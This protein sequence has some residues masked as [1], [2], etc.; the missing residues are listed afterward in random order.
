MSRA[1]ARFFN[2]APVLILE[3][4]GG[5]GKSTGGEYTQERIFKKTKIRPILLRTDDIPYPGGDPANRFVSD[6]EKEERYQ[7]VARRM[8][9][10]KHTDPHRPIIVEGAFNLQKFRNIVL[11][12]AQENNLNAYQALLTGP[13]STRLKR[14]RLHESNT[15]KRGAKAKRYGSGLTSRN[16]IKYRPALEEFEPISQTHSVIDNGPDIRRSDLGRQFDSFLNPILDRHSTTRLRDTQVRSFFRTLDAKPLDARE[17]VKHMLLFLRKEFGYQEK[18]RASFL[19]LQPSENGRYDHTNLQ[20]WH[21]YDEDKGQGEHI[22]HELRKGPIKAFSVT[23]ATWRDGQNYFQ[24]RYMPHERDRQYDSRI[25]KLTRTRQDNGMYFPIHAPSRERAQADHP[26]GQL[27]LQ[28][29]G[30]VALYS[31]KSKNPETYHQVGR[32]LRLGERYVQKWLTEDWKTHD[33]A[34][35]HV[36]SLIQHVDQNEQN[37]PDRRGYSLRIASLARQLGQ[38]TGQFTPQQLDQLEAAAHLHDAGKYFGQD[39]ERPMSPDQLLPH[40]QPNHPLAKAVYDYQQLTTAPAAMLQ[41]TQNNRWRAYSLGIIGELTEKEKN[42]VWTGRTKLEDVWR[43]HIQTIYN[44]P[45]QMDKLREG[46]LDI[47]TMTE[48][49]F[50]G[51]ANGLIDLRHTPLSVRQKQGL[52]D[53]FVVH[54]FTYLIQEAKH[55]E[56]QGTLE[57]TADK[58]NEI[59]RNIRQMGNIQSEVPNL[60]VY[61]LDPEELE[62][63]QQTKEK[64]VHII[65]NRAT[66]PIAALDTFKNHH[67]AWNKPEF[68]R[69][70]PLLQ[71][72]RLLGHNLKSIGNVPAILDGP[73]VRVLRQRIPAIV[74]QIQ[75]KIGQLKEEHRTVIQA[76]GITGKELE[77][78]ELLESTLSSEHVSQLLHRMDYLKPHENR[79]VFDVRELVKQF[80]N[81]KTTTLDIQ[82]RQPIMVLGKPSVLLDAIDNLL[83]NA[84]QHPRPGVPPTPKLSLQTVQEDGKN[85]VEL[86]VSDQGKG[87]PND[88]L[89][90]VAITHKGAATAETAPL[91]F[92]KGFT[93]RG[94]QGT[95]RGLDYVWQ[96]VKSHGGTIAVQSQ[97]GQGT[98]FR[99]RLPLAAPTNT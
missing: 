7:E 16:M 80:V 84:T 53:S 28:P 9:D 95:G 96:T 23:A 74:R 48:H 81:P 15:R 24:Q 61:D 88:L 77:N 40:F 21:A 29:M 50:H 10:S 98:T 92:H 57:P 30:I 31:E 85:W 94:E 75:K 36:A 45:G 32:F 17:K 76:T 18:G 41:D 70:Q 72:L 1:P 26:M 63:N 34:S 20:F 62:E 90:P 13:F 56:R 6:E 71:E 38:S 68:K 44:N 27:P 3:G 8:L 19:G 55:M 59:K 67:L 52:H 47:G 89:Q 82:A 64:L 78:A 35:R 65:G 4:K 83:V 11:N 60:P 86:Q 2:S 97:V 69:M 99:I 14:V 51:I 54:P 79:Q 33:P 22:V 5:V 46:R 58:L 93:T 66:L 39:P 42:A 25:E 91:I 73:T 43:R 12:A 87:I 49:E 37:L